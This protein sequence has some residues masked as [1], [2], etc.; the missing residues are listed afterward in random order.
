M[1]LVRILREFDRKVSLDL[2]ARIAEAREDE[3]DT[4]VNQLVRAKKAGRDTESMIW[5]ADR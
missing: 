4:E 5:L 1:R 2:L 3:V